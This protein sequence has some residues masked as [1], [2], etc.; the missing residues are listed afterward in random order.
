MSAAAASLWAGVHCPAL[1]LT[2][3]WGMLPE[4]GPV[5]VHEG[6]GARAVIVQS[7]RSGYRCGIRPGQTLTDALTIVPALQSRPRNR[8]M[9]QHALEQIALTAWRY[10]HQVI[11]YD[12]DTVVLEIAGSRRLYGSIEAL[13]DAL[14]ASLETRGFT[15][16]S[17]TAVAP[18][19]ACLLARLGRHTAD[20]SGLHRLLTTLP[21]ENL[22]LSARQQQALA[23]CGLQTAGELMRLP[24]AER[25]RRFGPELND[26]LDRISGKRPEA[27][28]NWHPPEDYR[29]HLDLPSATADTGALLFVFRRAIEHLGEW[30]EA[31]DHALLRLHVA[32]EREDGDS[33]VRFTVALAR[34]GMDHA[35]LLE[36][37]GLRLEPLRLSA[38]VIAI[39]LVAETTSE[40]R[41]PQTDLF[42][43][44]NRADAWPALLDRLTAR[45]GED[46]VS[47]LSARADHR[48]EKAWSWTDPGYST[49]LPAPPSRPPW[50]L[51]APRRCRRE[52]LFLEQGPERIESGWWDSLDCRRDYWIARDRQGYRL[53]VF[54]EYKPRCGWF[55]HGVFG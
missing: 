46:G 3:V 52:E 55:L 27:A 23:G 9:E 48:P 4:S 33:P 35:R 17:G 32:L 22:G 28:E 13:L 41:P 7:S 51:P 49:P 25:A 15:V 12:T 26:Y 21:L 50:L 34:P 14:H 37:I 44:R 53:W 1:P 19:A 45:L 43:A 24:P 5:A 30:L 8:G 29:L 11:L 36:L 39:G 42:S 40:H 54:R 18:A 38:P 2:A 16:R 10:S 47:S 20:L 6:S 31:R